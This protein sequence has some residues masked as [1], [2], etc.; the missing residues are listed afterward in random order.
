[1]KPHFVLAAL[2]AFFAISGQAHAGYDLKTYR[3]FEEKFREIGQA[4]YSQV[5]F[6]VTGLGNGLFWANTALQAR[7][8][9]PLFCL[10]PK[11]SLDGPMI[12]S[13]LDQEI[14]NPASGNPYPDD[15]PIEIIMLKSLMAR[16]PCA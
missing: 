6:Y 13:L 8:Q 12:K 2:F 11:L 14:A 1:M 5:R 16:F 3:E 9:P 7:E 15:K 10:P 4:E